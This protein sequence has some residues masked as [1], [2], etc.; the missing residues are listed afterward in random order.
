MENGLELKME[1]VK[2]N[3]LNIIKCKFKGHTKVYA[4]TCPFTGSTYEYCKRCSA[5][6]PIDKAD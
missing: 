6:I 5:M 3:L 2:F 1:K 4:G